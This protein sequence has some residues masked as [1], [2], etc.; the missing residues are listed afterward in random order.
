MAA[1]VPDG[2][3]E[4]SVTGAAQREIETLALLA[5]GLPDDYTVYHAV[6][7]TNVGPRYALYGE[8]DFAVVNRAGDLLLIE[9][10]SGFLAETPDGLVKQYPGKSKSV[11]IQISRMVNALRG[12]LANRGDIASVRT[13]ALLFC[14][15]YTVR[16][17]ETAGLAPERIVDA[18]RRWQLCSVIQSLLPAQEEGAATVK[19]HRFL[20]D[21]IQLDTDVSALMGRARSVVTRLSG[22][23]AH[24]ARQLDF[25]PYRLR[26]IGTAGSGKTQLALA[27]YRATVQLGKRPLYVCFNRPLA[28]HFSRIAPAGG[29]VCTFHQLCEQRLRQA[30]ET[31]DFTQPDA[32]QRLFTRAAVL[33]E[34]QA[35]PDLPLGNPFLFDTLIVDE[36]QDFSETWRDFVLRHARPTARLLW[37]E[38]PMQNLYGR[39]RVSLPDWITLHARSNYRSPRPIV[40][41]LQALLPGELDIEAASP[42]AVEEIAFIT[43]ADTAGMFQGV[44]DA[45]RDCYS[46]GFKKHDLAIVSYHGRAESRLTSLDQ[47][48]STTLR[49]F[50]GGYDLLGQGVFSEG[51]VLVDSV[52]RFK[53]QSAPAIIFA[54]IDFAELDDKAVR[55]L[56][57]G[58][59]R[60]TMQLVMVVHEKSAAQLRELIATPLM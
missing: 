2:W 42:I 52:Y 40:R 7:W 23:L 31:P 58:A 43:Y 30:G 4:L 20:R 51:D 57:V 50:T 59:T 19:I 27:E 44:K 16:F 41:M 35:S 54:E 48:G 29:L 15:D 1:I 25:S 53:G 21:L 5:E 49:H 28:D 13:D 8:I 12:K 60:S 10:K 17:P 38:D 46:A 3:R 18:G 26:V 32:F 39:P 14:P 33:P 9:Q 6:H 55:K 34:V 36:G 56:F 24:W 37:L 47:I 22:G 11:P 45:I